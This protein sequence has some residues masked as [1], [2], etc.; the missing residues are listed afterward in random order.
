[1]S[2][3]SPWI[4]WLIAAISTAAFVTLWFWEV[5]RILNDRKSTVDSAAGQLDAF[6]RRAAGTCCDGELTQVL[7]RSESIYYQAVRNYDRTL[8]RPWIYLPARLMG[9]RRIPQPADENCQTT[10]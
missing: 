9:F 1:M 3:M 5:R 2:S 10:V 8:S 4:A 7:R 6:R